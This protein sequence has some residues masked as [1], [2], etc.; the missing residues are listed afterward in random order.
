MGFREYPKVHRLDKEECN[1]IFDEPVT[2]QEKVDGANVSVYLDD[3]KI[4]CAS[5]KKIIREDDEFRGFVPYVKANKLIGKWL[6]ANPTKRLY[7]EWLVRHT[8]N[9]SELAWQKLY[10]FDV[11][12]DETDTWWEQT[13][14]EKLSTALKLPYP[15]I[16]ARDV[17]VKTENELEA[18]RAYVGQTNLGA[19]GEGVVIKRPAFRN[20]FGS[21]AY[22][23]LVHPKFKEANAVIFGSN[24]KSSPSYWE[25]TVINK[26]LTLG[27][28]EKMMHKI[29]PQLDHKIGLEDTPR[30]ISSV[31]HDM[32]TEEI[33]DI[34]RKVPVLDFKLL[35]RLST[36]KIVQVFHSI[37]NNTISVADERKEEA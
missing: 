4:V 34:A 25:M 1:G 32:L 30:M 9:Y 31:Y 2:V 20:E 12:D 8:I 15:Q 24:D 18:I 3:G 22:G 5:H 27:R 14:V 29:E 10:L 33:W 7:G 16:F 23:K 36:K 17:L 37:L 35:Q 19:A 21:L 13:E 26:Y 11:Y 6:K 28:V